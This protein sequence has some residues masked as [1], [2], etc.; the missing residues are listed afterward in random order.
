MTFS[1]AMYRSNLEPWAAA[2]TGQ[3]GSAPSGD[4]DP[5]QFAIEEC[6]KR[7]MELHAWVNPF[8]YSTSAKPYTDKYDSKLRPMLLTYTTRPKS[9]REKAKTYVILDPGNVKARQHV[10][11]VCRD[12][13]SRYDIDGLIF[14]DYFY[15]DRLPLGAG[16]DYNEWKKVARSYHKPT[17]DA[18]MSI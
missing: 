14:D 6:H 10:V 12:I 18:K 13:V 17:G 7:G 9:K 3:R 5:L 11:N 2:L 15:P 8:R 1:D 16:Y 4:W